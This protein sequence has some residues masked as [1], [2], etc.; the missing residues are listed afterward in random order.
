M[1]SPPQNNLPSPMME[2]YDCRSSR[3]RKRP[4]LHPSHLKN[5]RPLVRRPSLLWSSEFDDEGGFLDND[6]DDD[7]DDLFGETEEEFL[8]KELARLESLED[9]LMEIEQD[10]ES[11][12]DDND[13]DVKEELNGASGVEDLFSFLE[14]TEEDIYNTAEEEEEEEPTSSSLPSELEK[15][16]LQGVVPAA[17]G[18]GSQCLPGDWGFDPSDLATKD[19][20]LQIQY[21]LLQFMPGS[22]QGPPPPPRPSALIL[23]DYRE[24]EIRHGRLAM[25]AA[26]IWPLQEMLDRLLLDGEQFGPLIYG[27]ITLPYFP[28]FMTLAMMLLG[29]LDIYAKAIQDRDDI[30]D[31]FL[32]GDC[33]WDPLN[34]LEGAPASMKRNMQERELFN[35]RVAMLAFAAYVFE[36]ATTRI[37]LIEIE[38]N[39]L[40]FLPAYQIP[41]IQEWLDTQFSS[42]IYN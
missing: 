25:L 5:H 9:A 33:F 34:M 36:E 29:Y 2:P 10:L 35:G 23:R 15:A 12:L 27:P 20:I 1:V 37:P 24:A 8:R 17:A 22:E 38:G 28:L 21:R 13:E 19:Y 39:E 7:D 6:E 42:T 40:L 31:A 16:L 14:E 18:V 30:G 3:M 4:F 32:P 41:Y 11:F 26:M